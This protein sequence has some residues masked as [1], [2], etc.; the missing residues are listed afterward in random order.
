MNW[1][2]IPIN[3]GILPPIARHFHASVIHN[4]SMYI[5]GGFGGKQNLNDIYRYV[6]GEQNK[7]NNKNNNKI[8]LPFFKIIN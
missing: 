3:P 5:F 1:T 6:L 8:I 7:N 4:G 2:T